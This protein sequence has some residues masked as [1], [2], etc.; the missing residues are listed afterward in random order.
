MLPSLEHISNLCLQCQKHAPTIASLDKIDH[1]LDCLQIR[2]G[3]L[4]AS[5]AVEEFT[6]CAVSEKG[7]VPQR[8]DGDREYPVPPDRDLVTNFDLSQFQVPHLSLSLSSL[9][10]LSIPLQSLDTMNHHS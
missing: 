3:D 2:C 10:S 5:P 9:V 6:K 7:C 4:Y 1:I 8:K